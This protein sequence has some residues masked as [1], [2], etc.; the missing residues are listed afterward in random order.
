MTVQPTTTEPTLLEKI[1][2]LEVTALRLAAERDLALKMASQAT[3]DLVR[4]RRETEARLTDKDV[5]IDSLRI[6]GDARNEDLRRL[7]AR[8][9]ELAIANESQQREREAEQQRPEVPA[10]HR[11]LLKRIRNRKDRP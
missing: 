5:L 2:A 4:V 3:K 11:Q 7:S 10:A 9:H 1:H 8:V 6:A